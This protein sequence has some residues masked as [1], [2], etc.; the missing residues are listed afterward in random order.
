M[1]SLDDFMRAIDKNAARTK[2]YKQPGDGTNGEC[3]CIG[4]IIGGK[5]LAGGKWTGLHGSNYAARYEV[6]YLMPIKNESEMF[7]GEI[8]FKAKQPGD[9]GYALPER[10]KNGGAKYNGDLID[11]YHVGIVTKVKPLEVTHCT[12]Y[13]PIARDNKQGKWRFGGYLKGIDYGGISPAKDEVIDVVT[14]AGGNV[15]SPINMRESRSVLSRRLAEIPQNSEVELLEVGSEWSR[16]S[17]EGMTGYVLTKF[18]Q[19]GTDDKGN[20]SNTILV[21]RAELERAYDILGDL[22]GLRG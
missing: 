13:G 19:S 1:I 21:D 12:T 4:L 11:Y 10:Y 5:R 20:V 3:D 6:D 7:V 9:D 18:V 17:Y 22:L 8:V 16:I 2:T 15:K 14:L